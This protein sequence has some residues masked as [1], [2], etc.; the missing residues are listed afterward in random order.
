MSTHTLEG[1]DLERLLAR[2]PDELGP[3]ATI[4][5]ANKV[6]SGGIAG[7]FS[8]EGYE[9]VVEV[10][11]TTDV[12]SRTVADFE[13]PEL[14]GDGA[15]TTVATPTRRGAT[16]RDDD[17]AAVLGQMVRDAGAADSMPTPAVPDAL[18][19]AAARPV[20]VAHHGSF[21]PADAPLPAVDPA[22]R[23]PRRAPAALDRRDLDRMGLPASLAS[24]VA[25][26]PGDPAMT[27]LHLM[28]RVPRP[29]GLPTHQGSVIAVLGERKAAQQI[30]ERFADQLGAD[31]GDVLIAAR[32]GRGRVDD[33]RR[34]DSA[35]VALERRRSWRR[36]RRPTIVAIDANVSRR[37]AGWACALLEALEPTQVWGVVEATR[38]PEDIRE[39]AIHLGGL[40]ALAVHRIHDTA[41]P[42][43]VLGV[44]IPVGLIDGED[45]TALRWTS[46]L[47][48]RLQEAA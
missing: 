2:V 13:F 45:A 33:D 19:R 23:A 7:F 42:G 21:A 44:G 15:M 26:A 14:P 12:A 31:A 47:S 17:F 16:S 32:G 27:L 30:A 39:W 24:I 28:D 18:D 3:E 38:K 37:S 29:E 43:S 35:E 40:D 1:Q 9:V 6:R 41:S 10:D 11:D 20:P 36:R 25:A 4:V 34:I 48:A 46:I 8:R 22:R 5:A